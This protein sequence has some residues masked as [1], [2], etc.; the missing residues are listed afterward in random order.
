MLEAPPTTLGSAAPAGAPAGRRA[1]AR[2]IRRPKARGQSARQV[3][4]A[5]GRPM[6][7]MA[8]FGQTFHN[9]RR[10]WLSEGAA[11]GLG[12]QERQ[13][14]HGRVGAIL[15]LPAAAADEVCLPARPAAAAAREMTILLGLHVWN[16]RL[17]RLCATKSIAARRGAA[18]LRAPQIRKQIQ[19]D[20]LLQ[21]HVSTVD[22]E[23]PGLREEGGAGF[24]RLCSP[25]T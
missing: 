7:R 1:R 2:R 23:C 14:E 22:E 4:R 25:A 18:R 20:A 16:F 3:R 15:R 17:F 19:L 21:R 11:E 24:A 5:G 6:M 12:A 13:Y 9:R 10:R 8:K